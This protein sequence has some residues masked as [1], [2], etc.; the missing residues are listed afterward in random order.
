MPVVLYPFVSFF[1]WTNNNKVGA[2]PSAQKFVVVA[3]E[4]A[5]LALIHLSSS[6]SARFM[7]CA[8]HAILCI[9]LSTYALTSAKE[10]PLFFP[11][12]NSS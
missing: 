2:E 12:T 11:L 1:V 9:R 4:G 5:K 6:L 8:L 7:S 3:R 10:T